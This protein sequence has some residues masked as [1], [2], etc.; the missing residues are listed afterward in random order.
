MDIIGGR[1]YLEIPGDRQHELPPLLV[2]SSPQIQRLD[3][4]VEMAESIVESEDMLPAQLA[5]DAITTQQRKLDL[6]LHLVEQYKRLI[7][8]WQWGDDILE[9][10]RQCE[11]TFESR[12]ELRHLLRSDVWP[13][14]GRSSFVR[15]LEDKSVPTEGVQVEKAVGL[16]LT[17]RQPPP[18]SFLSNQFLF[19]LKDT[20][21]DSAYQTW[22]SKHPEP[23]SS[24]PPERF[25][26]QVVNMTM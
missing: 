20:V 1:T 24:L 2:H 15:L 6:A 11:I 16:R 3:K 23:V 17:F 8:H 14:A 10:I 13:H 26:L 4:I 7:L 22:A 18:I 9:W 12:P 25:T 19:Y 21:G 5:Y